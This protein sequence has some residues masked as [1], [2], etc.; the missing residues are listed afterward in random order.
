MEQSKKTIVL[1]RAT[2]EPIDELMMLSRDKSKLIA[3]SLIGNSLILA[4][5]LLA[6]D[7][8]DN[9]VCCRF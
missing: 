4:D 1:C 2:N 3:Q 5:Q 9:L 7:N 6:K 8:S